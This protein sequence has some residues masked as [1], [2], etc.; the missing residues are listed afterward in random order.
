MRWIRQRVE[1]EATLTVSVERHG[2]IL[3]SR[4]LVVSPCPHQRRQDDGHLQQ[5]R[6]EVPG[7]GRRGLPG[8]CG[9]RRHG[10]RDAPAS[11]V[12]HDVCVGAC[13]EAGVAVAKVLGDLVQRAAFVDEQRGAGVAE[14]VAAEVGD[15]GALESGDPDAAAPVVPTQVAALAVGSAGRAGRV[16]R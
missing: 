6:A 8:V 4:N 15:A 5:P 7:S 1:I 11:G 9:E 2:L 14:V 10:R 13:G 16:S 12:A 3:D